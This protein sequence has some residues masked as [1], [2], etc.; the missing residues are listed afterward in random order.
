[1]EK[2]NNYDALLANVKV[3]CIGMWEHLEALKAVADDPAK[4]KEWCEVVWLELQ[5]C[6]VA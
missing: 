6:K 5:K 3:S 2:L 1:M 4:V